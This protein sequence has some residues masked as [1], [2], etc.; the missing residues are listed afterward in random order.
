MSILRWLVLRQKGEGVMTPRLE[1][2]LIKE[3]PILFKQVDLPKTQTCMC[4][5]IDT[6]DGWHDILRDTCRKI[7]DICDANQ[8]TVEF[9]QVK[10]KFGILRIYFDINGSGVTFDQIDKIVVSAEEQSSHT[11]EECGKKGRMNKGGWPAVRCDVCRRKREG[12]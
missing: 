9:T 2:Q 4:W 12:L 3:F 8:C 11:C 5:G 6:G 1:G 7:Q 10:E